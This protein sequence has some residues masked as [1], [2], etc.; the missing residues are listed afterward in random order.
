MPDK[1]RKKVRKS[2]N[3][4]IMKNHKSCPR[5]HRIGFIEKREYSTSKK[6]HTKNLTR[7]NYGIY[8]IPMS[9]LNNHNV[10]HP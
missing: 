3:T 7:S 2:S 6:I 4:L 8:I 10:K 9:P 1:I 5:S